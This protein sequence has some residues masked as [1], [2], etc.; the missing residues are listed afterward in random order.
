M[1]SDRALF[2]VQGLVLAGQTTKAL[3]TLVI[4]KGQDQAIYQALKRCEEEKRVP[5]LVGKWRAHEVVVPG[6]RIQLIPEEGAE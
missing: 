3:R 6:H 5:C 2:I 4:A 1:S